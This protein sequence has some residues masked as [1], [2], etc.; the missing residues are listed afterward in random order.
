MDFDLLSRHI[1]ILADLAETNKNQTMRI[2]DFP[3]AAVHYIPTIS[4]AISGDGF[5]D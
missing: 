1:F 3:L 2:D 5:Y 4:A